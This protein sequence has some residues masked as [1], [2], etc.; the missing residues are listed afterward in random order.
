VLI[1]GRTSAVDGDC[2]SPRLSQA[3]VSEV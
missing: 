2:Q 1:D 3:R